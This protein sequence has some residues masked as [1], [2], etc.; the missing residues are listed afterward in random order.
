MIHTPA[1][2]VDGRTKQRHKARVRYGFAPQSNAQK[3]HISC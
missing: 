2:S 3:N 1:D